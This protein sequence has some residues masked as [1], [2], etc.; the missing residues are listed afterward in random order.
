LNRKRRGGAEPAGYDATFTAVRAD[1]AHHIADVAVIVRLIAIASGAGF[2]GRAEPLRA[3]CR[4]EI[5]LIEPERTASVTREM[6][7]RLNG[8][9]VALL[10]D[11]DYVSTGPTGW[12]ALPGLLRWSTAAMIRATGGDVA[13]YRP[14]I[15]MAILAR[16]FLLIETDS[17]HMREWADVLSAPRVPFIGLQPSVGA[18]PVMPLR[19]A[20]Q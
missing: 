9:V 6:F 14:A 4:R 1:G 2:V 8:P 19:G 12:A 16:R 13:S 18:H 15:G 10:A 5:A 17:A 3:V 7:G 11:D 20:M